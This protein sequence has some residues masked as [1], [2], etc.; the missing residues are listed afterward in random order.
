MARKRTRIDIIGDMLASI[1]NKGGKIKPTHLMYNSNLSH[2]QMSSYLDDL[3]EKQLVQKV[4]RNK[5]E[6]IGITDKGYEFMN[7]LKEMK[8]FE[9][10]FGLADEN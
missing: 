6:Y 3:I 10:A 8:E 9:R 4:E 1:A 7:K 2:T 5:Y